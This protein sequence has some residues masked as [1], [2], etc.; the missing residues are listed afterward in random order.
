MNQ[1]PWRDWIPGV[2][3]TEQ[4]EEL[5][6]QD[7]LVNVSKDCIGYSSFD[8][9]IS[10][11]GYELIEGAVKPS[12]IS[13]YLRWLQEQDLVRRI[14]PTGDRIFHLEPRR[15][16]LF[17]L[18]ERF[19]KGKELARAQIHGNATAKSS[20]G[21]LDVLARY[22]LDGMGGYEE[23]TP[24]GLDGGTGD[25]YLEVT[26]L[27]FQV[28]IGAGDLLSQLRLF[29]G[30]PDDVEIRGSE[31]KKTIL[32][33]YDSGSEIEGTL[34]VDLTPVP[35]GGL[36][37][38][39]FSSKENPTPIDMSVLTSKQKKGLNP[40]D[41]WLIEQ[42]S[43]RKRLII[44]KDKFYILRSKERL[45]VPEGIAIYG[46]A[47][48]ETIGEMRIH[49]AGF[50]HPFFGTRRDDGK[51]GT[52]LIFEVR[53]H[54]INVVLK[55]GERMARLQFYRMSKDAIFREKSEDQK[56][57]Y[58]NQELKLSG[59]FDAWPAKLRRTDD[60]SVCPV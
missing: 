34:S 57:N 4:M 59:V 15:T 43:G 50:V 49:Y 24:D 7:F 1:N 22:I 52:P 23:I 33:S 16:Y 5:C 18:R 48:D 9:A 20:I 27:T 3:S 21:R 2:L 54:D 41:Y 25:M 13:N 60:G 38:V 58:M 30:K 26:P 29:Y 14:Q 11:E 10:E 6:E 39:A 17:K 28:L 8:L 19:A 37:A 31:I 53:G 12:K 55:D 56:R 36:D 40:C 32:R 46:R 47:M 51:I 42:A 45:W 35:V 44:K